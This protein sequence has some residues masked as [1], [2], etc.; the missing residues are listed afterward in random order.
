VST[1]ENRRD[2]LRGITFAVGSLLVVRLSVL[3]VLADALRADE[4][5]T[6]AAGALPMLAG[7][8]AGI[9]LLTVSVWHLTAISD[10][11]AGFFGATSS[12]ATHPRHTTPKNRVV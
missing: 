7:G 5:G 2:L 8:V 11:S 1:H 10:R 3:F 9:A 4:T 6:A 12:D